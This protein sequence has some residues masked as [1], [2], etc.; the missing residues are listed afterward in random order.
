MYLKHIRIDKRLAKLGAASLILLL[1]L[2]I[3]GCSKQAKQESLLV[4]G[5]STMLP[6]MEK[7]EAGFAKIHPNILIESDGG[8]STA[9]IIAVKRNAIDLATMSRDVRRG[10]DDQYIRDY[11]VAKD[12]IAIVGHPSNPVATLSKDQV[13]DIFLGAITN[14]RQLGGSD[15]PIVLAGRKKGSTTRKGMDEM[16]LGGL[17]FAKSITASESATA[18]REIVAA[19]PNAIGYLALKDLNNSVKPVAVNG[20]AINRE[21]HL[22]WALSTKPFLL[23]SHLRQT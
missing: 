15:S 8:G 20:V 17:D 7:L 5:S 9:G 10:E 4:A 14:W 12:A 21:K 3:L 22:I 1:L 23:F 2:S 16:L 19:N 11:L 18:L 13:R 6:Y